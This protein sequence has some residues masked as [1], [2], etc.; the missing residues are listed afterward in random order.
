MLCRGHKFFIIRFKKYYTS[1]LTICLT[2]DMF[3]LTSIYTISLTQ[4][5]SYNIFYILI[6]KKNMGRL[7]IP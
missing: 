5:L 7:F 6:D 2:K 1:V 3:L 4:R